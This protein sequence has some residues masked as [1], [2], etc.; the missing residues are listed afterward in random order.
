VSALA[1]HEA[2]LPTTKPQP[3]VKP[4]Q[5]PRRSRPWMYVPPE[6]GYTA[7]SCAEATALQ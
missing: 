1:A 6:V 2:V 3:A 4:H 7:A 5:C